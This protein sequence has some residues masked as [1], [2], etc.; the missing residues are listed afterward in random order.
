VVNKFLLL[1]LTALVT[2]SSL[3]SLKANVAH[4][5][6]ITLKREVWEGR[7]VLSDLYR[8]QPYIAQRQS[9]GGGCDLRVRKTAAFLS[10]YASDLAAKRAGVRNLRDAGPFSVQV[11]RATAMRRV[12]DVVVCAPL[13]GD[14][15]FR[16]AQ[17]S[18]ALKAEPSKT[19]T[20]LAWSVRTAPH[21]DRIKAPRTAFADR[22]LGSL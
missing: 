5:E 12:R 19:E 3:N 13:D 10:L 18:L 4:F 6:Y 2:V 7:E 21:E 17:L 1:T 8:L 20:Y 14:M 22:N 15:W 11:A 16:L 9:E